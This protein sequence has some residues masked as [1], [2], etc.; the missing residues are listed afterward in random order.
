MRLQVPSHPWPAPTL[1]QKIVT[2]TPALN[3]VSVG[4]KRS[5][6]YE[7][8]LSNKEGKNSEC[9]AGRSLWVLSAESRISR[10][11]FQIAAFSRPRAST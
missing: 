1:L 11:E 7:R 5:A 4:L 9:L 6:Q 3:S 8:L 2:Y 10:A